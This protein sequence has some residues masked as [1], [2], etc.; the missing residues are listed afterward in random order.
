MI[1]LQH[2]LES[3]NTI[4]T[5]PSSRLLRAE[6]IEP[7]DKR[8]LTFISSQPHSHIFHHPYWMDLLGRT[9]GYRP[10]VMTEFDGD[11]RILAGLPLM[12]VNSP[13]TGRRWVSLPFTDYCSPT[14]NGGQ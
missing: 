1:T 13:L 11:G 14:N 9:Y 12:E 10:F 2:S 8:W 6:V 3:A 7:A 5:L 4:R